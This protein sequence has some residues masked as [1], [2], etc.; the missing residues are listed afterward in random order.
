MRRMETP[1]KG[2]RQS[3]S[4]QQRL[5]L[6]LGLGGGETGVYSYCDPGVVWGLGRRGQVCWS[7]R[8]AATGH[9]TLCG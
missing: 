5:Q 1:S 4:A 2:L 6:P 7:A 3:G 8:A 9:R